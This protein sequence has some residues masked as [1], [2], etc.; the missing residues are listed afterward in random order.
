[1]TLIDGDAPISGPSTGY[2]SLYPI[3]N[4]VGGFVQFIINRSKY[5]FNGFRPTLCFDLTV[6]V[7]ADEFVSGRRIVVVFELFIQVAE[8]F[9][10]LGIYRF[11]FVGAVTR[12]LKFPLSLASLFVIRLLISCV[13]VICHPA[14]YE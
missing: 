3:P 7:G 1:M 6:A 10:G 4:V 13:F 9:V 12:L 5:F 14:I 11:G 2:Q 8:L